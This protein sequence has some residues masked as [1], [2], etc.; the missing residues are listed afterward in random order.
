ME[1]IDKYS[2][3]SKGNIVFNM[4]KGTKYVY[5]KS[6]IKLIIDDIEYYV[7]DSYYPRLS[8]ILVP[9][10]DSKIID[11]NKLIHISYDKIGQIKI[12]ED[13]FFEK[14]NT[15]DFSISYCSTSFI[16]CLKSYK[17]I[18]GLLSYQY[19]NYKV[20]SK[21]LEN[22]YNDIISDILNKLNTNHKIFEKDYSKFGI[23]YHDNDLVVLDSNNSVFIKKVNSTYIRISS[24]ELSKVNIIKILYELINTFKFNYKHVFEHIEKMFNCETDVLYFL[25]HIIFKIKFKDSNKCINFFIDRCPDND[26]D[27]S[28]RIRIYDE[29]HKFYKIFIDDHISSHR[30]TVNYHLEQIAKTDTIIELY[31]KFLN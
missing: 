18:D 9:I 19:K 23:I 17:I 8:I 28:S 16:H 27:N 4:N 20:I 2:L 26:D 1:T 25:S 22:K 10:L 13:S 6:Q 12:N 11:L 14:I 30:K 5:H 3:N 21:Y 31:E 29:T 24:S 7:F 15:N